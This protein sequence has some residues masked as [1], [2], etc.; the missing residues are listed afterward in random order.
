MKNK[1]LWLSIGLFNLCIVALLGFIL[2][3][4]IIFDLPWIN[5]L[6]VLDAHSHFTFGGWV[7]LA[8]LVLLVCELLPEIF[9]NRKVYTWVFG[10]IFL[11]SMGNLL[12]MI[13]TGNIF[14]AN[15]FFSLFLLT[16][17]VFAWFFIRQIRLTN[18]NKTVYLLSVAAVLSLVLSSAGPFTIFYLHATG[19]PHTYFFR[20][21]L[22]VYLHLQYNGFFTLSVFALLFNKLYSD[23]SVRQKRNSH[24]FSVLL[25]VSLLPSLFLSFLWQEPNE[26]FRQIAIV[27]SILTLATALW[28]ILS[29]LPILNFF[30]TAVPVERFIIVLSM[31]AFFTKMILQSLTIIR[32][33]GN[34]VFGNRPVIIGFLHL[35]FL[36]FVTPF[37]LGW[38]ARGRILSL[39]IKLTL[40]A[41]NL[42]MLSAIGNEGLLMLQGVGAMFLK[43]GYLFSWFLWVVSIG[44]LSGAVLTFIACIRSKQFYYDSIIEGH[45]Y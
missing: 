25:C 21:A 35:V 34:A 22:Y 9:S 40:D 27:G 36:A 28:F 26:L 43:G 4:K 3:S 37:I 19:S 45:K 1:R 12:V 15:V 31:S 18:P 44:L 10:L 5:Y 39:K 32:S 16:A 29:V 7:T 30:K 13:V 6:N 38:L 8:L 20:D 23:L 24:I 42:F 17:Y 2:R 11:T 14:L 33:V 41:L